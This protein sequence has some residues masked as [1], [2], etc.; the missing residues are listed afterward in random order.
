MVIPGGPLTLQ[1]L[2]SQ[3][4][5][6]ANDT[7]IVTTPDVDQPTIIYVNPA[8]TRLTGY[9]FDEVVGRTPRILQGP[10]TSRVTRDLI[11]Q[12]LQ[13]GQPVHEK[14][15]NYVKS[16]APYWLDLRIVPLH[17]SS[18]AITQFAAIE[19]DVTFDKRRLDE[20]DAAADRDV[21]TGIP[22]RRMFLRAAEAELIVRNTLRIA[23]PCFATVDAD[24]LKAI[25]RTVGR[26]AGDA[27][28]IGIADRLTENIRRVDTIGRWNA[29]SFAICMHSATIATAAMA[30]ECLRWAVAAEPFDTPAGPI[31]ATVSIGV[32]ASQAGEDDP[33]AV[34]ARTEAAV[35]Q[36]KLD[37]RDRVVT[38]P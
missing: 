21:L 12:G 10:G 3:I 5:E 34:M 27:I 13:A 38:A 8:F 14:I 16:G 37:G 23:G 29:G 36:A 30:A 18:G 9:T 6:H 28:L 22:N 2:F 15:L 20:F 24:N 31:K 1:A 35:R 4:V 11:R 26:D 25:N 19:R 17:D 33:V 7:I 32:A